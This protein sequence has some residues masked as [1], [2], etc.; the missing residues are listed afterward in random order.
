MSAETP[1]FGALLKQ[2]RLA[3]GLTQEALAERAGLSARAISDLERGVNRAPRQDTL[4]LLSQ[5]LRLPPRKRASLVTAARPAVDTAAALEQSARTLHNL[6]TAP[7]PL[8]GRDQDVARATKLLER[9]EVR[10]LTLTGPSGVGKTRLGL[11]V[12]EDMLERCDDGAWFVALASIH[13]PALVAPAIAQ[14]LDLRESAGQTPQSLLQDALRQQRTLLLL[15]NFEQVGEAAPLIAELLSACPRLKVLVTSRATLHLRG[16]YELAVAPLEQEPAVTLFLQRAQAA[17]PD[18]ECSSETLQAIAAIC[19]RLDRLPLAIELAAARMKTLPAPALLAR[20]SSRLLLLTGGALDL[21]ER[22]RTMRDAVAW[23]YELL[24]SAEQRLFR[25]LAVFDGGCALEAAE[26]IC[27]SADQAASDAVLEGLTVLVD[28]SLLRA[29]RLNGAPR[30]TMLEIIREYAL[31]QLQ[32]RGEADAQRRRH[33]EY[34]TKLAEEASRIGPGQ[35]ARDELVTQESANIRAAIAWAR[36][37]RECDLGLRLATACGRIWY[38][39]G[40]VSELAGWFEDLLALDDAAGEHAATPAVRLEALY[41]VGQIAMDQGQY[42]RVEAVARESLALAEQIGNES[43]IGNALAQLGVAAEA[44]GD[45]QSA[46]QFL[47]EGLIHCRKA[48]DIG[49]EQRALLSLGHIY[50]ALGDYPRATSCFK[51]ALEQARSINLTWGIANVLT[52][53]G[54][55]AREQGDHQRALARY[56]ESLALHRSF[57]NKGYIAWC[58]EGMA[59]ALCAGGQLEQAAQ[60]CAAAAA[61]RDSVHAPRPPAEQRIYDQTIAATRSALGEA[62]FQRA[63]SA[64]ADYTLEEVIS[65]ALAD[66]PDQSAPLDEERATSARR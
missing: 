18:L 20:L 66:A 15:D 56:R 45:L 13:D 65:S 6:P 3:A 7:T 55:L 63:W 50:R 40:R 62:A 44:R 61:L 27:S 60:L 46:A 41:G 48:G 9:P 58:F 43:G 22:Q 2:Y 19:Q 8:I 37:H 11:Q 64:G 47:E 12:A 53:L 23:S 26:A 38:I 54:H 34:Y 1:S 5:A 35:D 32:A 36:A 25:S 4:D 28:Q 14:A 10:L 16:E 30:F 59:A 52:S 42:D 17:R 29:E 57:G 33:A 21:P 49:G 39:R 24:S 31:E 51:Q